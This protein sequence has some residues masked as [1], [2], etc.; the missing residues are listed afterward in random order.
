MWKKSLARSNIN[1]KCK[2]VVCD[3]IYILISAI[4]NIWVLVSIVLKWMIQFMYRWW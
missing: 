2:I 1:V 3:S 4:Y